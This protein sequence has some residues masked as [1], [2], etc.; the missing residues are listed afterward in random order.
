MFKTQ[1]IEVTE[2]QIVGV[3]CDK[4]G[5][6]SLFSADEE[7]EAQEYAHISHLGGYSSIFGDGSDM[8]LTFN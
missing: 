2:K 1:E 4:C 7:Y 3:K 6:E 8:V 5:K